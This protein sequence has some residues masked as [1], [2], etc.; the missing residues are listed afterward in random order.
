MTTANKYATEK[1]TE[2]DH[3][4]GLTRGARPTPLGL[5]HLTVDGR[6]N[7]TQFP[8]KHKVGQWLVSE[9]PSPSPREGCSAGNRTNRSKGTCHSTARTGL[10]A[11]LETA[12]GLQGTPACAPSCIQ[13][14][15]C[16]WTT[17]GPASEH[18]GPHLDW[19]CP[20]LPVRHPKCPRAPVSA[21][22]AHLHLQIGAWGV[23]G[24]GAKAVMVVPP[25]G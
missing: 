24:P 8:S 2:K 23:P 19:P 11:P 16:R 20:R 1:K 4:G 5:G 21:S 14:Q 3:L 25:A 7:K 17:D 15:T 6:T 10:G 12:P 9:A 22:R 13:N 18:P